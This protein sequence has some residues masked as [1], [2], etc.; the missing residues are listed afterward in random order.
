MSSLTQAGPGTGTQV[1]RRSRLVGMPLAL[2][3]MAE[4]ASLTSFLLLISVM[5]MLAAAVAEMTDPGEMI[6][7]QRMRPLDR[8]RDS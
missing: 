8:W 4:F 2:T 3:F 1:P 6:L 5:P 7:A